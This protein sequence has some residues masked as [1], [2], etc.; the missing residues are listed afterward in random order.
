[1]KNALLALL[2]VFALIHSSSAAG[3]YTVAANWLKLPDGRAQL[4]NQHGDVAVSSSGDVYVSVQD[5]AAGLQVFGPDGKFLR[6]VNGA[7]SDFHGFVIHKEAAGAD[8]GPAG[9]GRPFEPE[10][11]EFMPDLSTTASRELHLDGDHSLG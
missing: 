1:M 2:L 11:A 9:C 3:D 4:G 6:N 7:P 5:T 10:E 8:A